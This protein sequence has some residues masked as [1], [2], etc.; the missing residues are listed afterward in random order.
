MRKIFILYFLILSNFW[1]CGQDG[2]QAF[3]YL[4][5]PGSARAAA[6]GGVNVSIVENDLSLIYHNP[7]FLGQEM[8]RTLNVNY[9][10]YV[11]DVKLG[12]A[13]FAK[14]FGERSAWGIGVN[15]SNYGKM[16]ETTVNN[17][18]L[19]DLNA[20]DIC[21]NI[22]FSGDLTETIRGGVAAK[23][24]YSNYWHNTA[25]GLGVDLGISYYNRDRNLSIGLVGKNLGRQVKAYEEEL[26]NLPWDIQLGFS[27]KLGHAPIRYSITAVHLNQWKFYDLHQE[28]GDSF[29]RTLFK[30]VVFG[31]EFLPTENFWIAVGYNVKRGSDM[32]LND[33]GN[34]WG[35]FSIG[36]G[37]KLKSFNLGCSVAKYHPAATSFM[38]SIS[39][40][41]AET[42]L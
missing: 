6:L 25:I 31:V 13:T 1:V 9:L 29:T 17:D 40:S 16:L 14:A 33:G 7:G 24:V 38:L 22:F 21:G 27:Q 30:H 23:F 11:G 36:A 15:Y 5:L 28:E 35:A 19:G 18:I 41:L 2:N 26:L 39:T 8:D 32:A 3:T 42:K 4:L 34:K 10:S 20:S 37:L 12:S